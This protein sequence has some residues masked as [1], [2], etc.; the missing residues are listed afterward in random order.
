MK[1]GNQG[2]AVWSYTDIMIHAHHE[3][4]DTLRSMKTGVSAFIPLVPLF[5]FSF[6]C[7]CFEL[8]CIC[9]NLCCCLLFGRKKVSSLRVCWTTKGSLHP[10]TVLH[11]IWTSFIYDIKRIYMNTFYVNLYIDQKIH[12]LKKKKNSERPRSKSRFWLNYSVIQT[13]I[14]WMSEERISSVTE[15]FT[16]L[17]NYSLIGSWVKL[18]CEPVIHWFKYW[19]TK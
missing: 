6:L 15:R 5:Y 11:F 4:N 2:W 12:W 16:E 17:N 8:W 19:F 18:G 13:L 7:S 10:K 1:K 3:T 9:V 14:L